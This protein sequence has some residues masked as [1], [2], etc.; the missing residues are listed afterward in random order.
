[1]DLGIPKGFKG[2]TG[3]PGK[4]LWGSAA[5]S[6]RRDSSAAAS[7]VDGEMGDRPWTTKGKDHEGEAKEGEDTTDGR[8]GVVVSDNR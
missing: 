3:T 2:G 5:P 1:M 7:A 6:E 4:M 8:A